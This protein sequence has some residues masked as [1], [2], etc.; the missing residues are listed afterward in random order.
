[1][2]KQ[3]KMQNK[4]IL[5]PIIILATL[6]VVSFIYNTY[7]RLQLNGPQNMTISYRD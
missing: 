7:P 5:I 1:M 3:T 2:K 4:T 6:V